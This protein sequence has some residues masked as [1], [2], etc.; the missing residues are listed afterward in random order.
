MVVT[1]GVTHARIGVSKVRRWITPDNCFMVT[2]TISQ[3]TAAVTTVM[4]TIT[5]HPSS[6]VITVR[7]KM[8]LGHQ[9]RYHSARLCSTVLTLRGGFVALMADARLVTFPRGGALPSLNRGR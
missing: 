5:F 8:D 7:Q 2:A 9:R 4:G 6:N 1:V 3:R